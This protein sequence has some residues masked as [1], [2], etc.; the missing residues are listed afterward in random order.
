[1]VGEKKN[2]KIKCAV[3]GKVLDWVKAWLPGRKKRTVLNG[4]A[5]N[6]TDVD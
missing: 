5:S 4:D 3:E 6:W 1:M 2:Y